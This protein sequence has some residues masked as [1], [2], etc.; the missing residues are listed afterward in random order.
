L[1]L[2]ARHF[3]IR[4]CFQTPPTLLSENALQFSAAAANAV[5]LLAIT[6]FGAHV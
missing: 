2:L 1:K 3:G 4:C 6:S 5:I